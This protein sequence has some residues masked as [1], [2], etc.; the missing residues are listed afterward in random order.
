MS[1]QVHF[2][3]GKKLSRRTVLRGTAG[4]GIAVP[5]LSAM[6]KAFAGP[7]EQKTPRRFVAMTL[8]LGLHAENLNPEK[9]GRDYKPSPYLEKLQDIREKFTVI[10]G[11]S[12]PHVSGGHR[13]EASLLSA[14]P[15]GSGAQSR[16]TISVDQLL[17]K[18]MGHHT[19]FPSLVLSSAGNASPS[20]TENGSM[21]PAESSPARLF[22]QLFVNDSPADQAKQ[23]HR[24]R[25]GKSI[26]DLVAED[27]KSLSRELGAGD[28]DRLAAYFNSVR[29][30]EK[31]MAEAEQWAHLPKP[32]VDS[33]KPIDISNPNDFIGRQRLMNDMIR[34]ALST[35][36][37]RFVSYHLGGS[38]GVVPIEG[39]EE[40]YHSLSHHGRDEEKLSQLA[41]I[42]TS[43]VHAW[44]DFLRGL[45]GI[46]EDGGSLLDHTSVLLTSNLGNASSHDNR[47]MPVLFAGGGFRHGQHLAFDQK[48]NY[49]LPNLY[50]SMLQKSGLEIDQ[51]A[52]STGTM[53][54]LEPS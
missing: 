27:A 4:V 1:R 42:E 18:H 20:Y 37:T 23:L 29:E 16:T 25:Q 40:G 47:N 12:H 7:E 36:S 54:G 43:I 5:W 19:R 22:M 34:L 11:S 26:M 35:D 24:A 53:T 32:K 8:G 2:N 49:P 50:L 13:A 51:F 48:K 17:A 45:D 30:L 21:I 52:T 14:T 33:K 41:L 39:V 15:M 31:R 28:R 46:Q 38:G 3:F 10:S 6:Q 44:G 9:A